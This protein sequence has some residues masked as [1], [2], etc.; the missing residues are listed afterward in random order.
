M[1]R[2]RDNETKYNY[3]FYLVI[4]KSAKITALEK[5]N[6]KSF[7]IYFDILFDQINPKFEEYHT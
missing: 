3:G 2:I 5:K 1:K 4:F 6:T 7:M